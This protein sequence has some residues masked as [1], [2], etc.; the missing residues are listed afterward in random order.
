MILIGQEQGFAGNGIKSGKTFINEQC[1]LIKSSVPSEMLNGGTNYG[2][3]LTTDGSRG[4][5]ISNNYGFIQFPWNDGNPRID[6]NFGHWDFDNQ[7]TWWTGCAD[8]SWTNSLNWTELEVPSIDKEIKFFN[9]SIISN[10]G[11]NAFYPSFEAGQTYQM[12]GLF[13]EENA[14]ITIPD[15]GSELLIDVSGTTGG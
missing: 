12:K 4:Y 1:A 15:N 10:N 9:Q 2:T 5:K 8:D 3:I 11:L 13:L 7:Y 14:T 6:N